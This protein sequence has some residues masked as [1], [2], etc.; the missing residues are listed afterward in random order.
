[1]FVQVASY[2][3]QE[4]NDLLRSHGFNMMYVMVGGTWNV[5]A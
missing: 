3:V 4:S 2:L 5:H 1:M